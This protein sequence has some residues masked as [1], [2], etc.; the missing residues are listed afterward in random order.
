MTT[1]VKLLQAFRKKRPRTSVRYRNSY[2]DLFLPGALLVP[3]CL[4]CVSSVLAQGDSKEG[5]T[6]TLSSDY[7]ERAGYSVKAIEI[8]TPIDF[9]G[10]VR[11]PLQA[12]LAASQAALA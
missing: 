7:Y 3:L 6:C 5:Q 11:K 9:V 10:V 4:L 12:K 8:E 1:Q 2:R